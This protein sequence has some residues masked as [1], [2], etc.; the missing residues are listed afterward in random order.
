MR[1]VLGPL[2]VL[3]CAFLLAP[4]ANAASRVGASA[5]AAAAF[6]LHPDAPEVNRQAPPRFDVRLETS[7]GPIV[8][9]VHRDWAP[10]GADRF[11]NLVRAG[12]YDGARFF[13]VIRGRWAQ[14]G[15]N[16][17]PRISNAWRTR[18]FADDP[19]RESNVRGTVAFAFA[20]PNGRTTQVFIN[21]RDNAATLDVEP[22]A[23]FGAVVEGMD[24]A[25]ALDAEYG[26]ASGSGIRAGRQA[27][28]FEMG[29]GYLE[30]N[31]PRLDYIERTTVL[32]PATR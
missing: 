24:V 3:A 31:F 4:C 10:H 6:L 17:D 12:Y 30:R 28:L 5:P 13:R 9:A 2:S 32:R 22:F 18:T 26:E 29:N 8:I 19:R 15:I 11:Y 1:R 16:G 7:K 23:P 25:D 21:L 27:P 20:V 14:F